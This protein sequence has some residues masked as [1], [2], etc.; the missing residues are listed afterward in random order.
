MAWLQRHAWWGLFAI[1]VI[2]M[3]FGL[4][5][6]ASG[7]AADVGIPQGLTGRTIGDLEAESADAYGLFDFIT[8]INGLSLALIGA[9]LA[10][11]VL[12]PFRRGERWA[13]WTAWA[14]PIWAAVVPIFYLVAGVQPDEP[15]PPPMVSGPI[16]AVLCAAILL[17]RRPR[18]TPPRGSA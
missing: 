5:D 17:V 13:W 16:V 9:L 2:V 15:P 14:L 4:T 6:I 8:R 3:L 12:I 7:A 18:A 10:V 11:I 1:S